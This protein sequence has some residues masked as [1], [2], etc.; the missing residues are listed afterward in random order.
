[1]A[2]EYSTGVSLWCLK[3]VGHTH[4]Q[5]LDLLWNTKRSNILCSTYIHAHS[6]DVFWLWVIGFFVFVACK[7]IISRR[8]TSNK[9]SKT[10]WYEKH[11]RYGNELKTYR[12]TFQY[13]LRIFSHL[14]DILW[15][16][17]R[18]LQGRKV[19]TWYLHHDMTP[20]MAIL[21]PYNFP[22]AKIL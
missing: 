5:V 11:E 3:L 2:E 14:W 10:K 18:P 6:T 7:M 19:Y 15:I 4:T 16:L 1:M 9:C 22:Q 12:Y 21:H 17:N 20:D 8:A 13:M